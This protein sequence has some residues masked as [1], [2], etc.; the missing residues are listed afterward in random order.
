[1]AEEAQK[2]TYVCETCGHEA[3]AEE[4]PHCCG[5]PMK[6]KEAK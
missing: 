3:T 5:L 6:D 1:M 4:A 2:K